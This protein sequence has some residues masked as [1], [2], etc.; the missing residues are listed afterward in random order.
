MALPCANTLRVLARLVEAP[1]LRMKSL[2]L[3]NKR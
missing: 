1:Y 2:E 3:K